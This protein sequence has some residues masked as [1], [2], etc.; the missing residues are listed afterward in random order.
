M[1]GSFFSLLGVLLFVSG[2]KQVSVEQSSQETAQSV[3]VHTHV[4]V[5]IYLYIYV[6]ISNLSCKGS[7]CMVA[8][9]TLG[10]VP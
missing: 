7:N 9:V 1:P 6:H 10:D 2:N 4:C 3:F 8:K 5:Y